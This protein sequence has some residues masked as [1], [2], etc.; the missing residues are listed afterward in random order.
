MEWSCKFMW[1]YITIHLKVIK[2][3]DRFVTLWHHLW[4]N[5]LVNCGVKQSDVKHIYFRRVIITEKVKLLLTLTPTSPFFLLSKAKAS[6]SSPPKVSKN[7]TLSVALVAMASLTYPVHY[8][9]VTHWHLLH[10]L[11]L[12]GDLQ[13]LLN[14]L[15]IG[16]RVQ[17]NLN[18]KQEKISS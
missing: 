16:C 11:K 7:C 13:E 10:V 9:E 12:E 3:L 18:L 1:Q 8:F 4:W 17:F 2:N 5:F 15:K 14:H 6:C